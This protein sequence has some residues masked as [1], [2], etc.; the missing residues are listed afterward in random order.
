MATKY[1]LNKQLIL[2]RGF[3]SPEAYNVL[4][5]NTAIAWLRVNVWN[6]EDL[7]TAIIT[8]PD[9][10]AWWE[11]QWNLRDEQFLTDHI[12][13]VLYQGCSE[14]LTEDEFK[15]EWL[16]THEVRNIEMLPAKEVMRKAYND[17]INKAMKQQAS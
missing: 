9:F 3:I 17:V 4:Q 7:I 11:N 14:F 8:Q 13:Y 2:E 12:E 10:W 5:W 6:D 15:Q 16:L 1:V